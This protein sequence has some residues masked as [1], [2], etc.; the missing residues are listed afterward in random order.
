MLI[1]RAQRE[2]VKRV[3]DRGPIYLDATLAKSIHVRRTDYRETYRSFRRRC[4]S[5]G[6]G[7][8]TVRWCGM[9]LAIE[10]DGYEWAHER[11][12][13]F[14]ATRFVKGG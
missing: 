13:Y 5:A 12:R 7:C 9:W 14:L 6:F 2:A 8:I 11:V 4:F 3:Y 1:T 10:Q